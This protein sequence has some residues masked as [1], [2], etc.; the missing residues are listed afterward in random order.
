MCPTEPDIVCGTDGR[1]YTNLCLLNKQACQSKSQL[2]I[3]YKGEC[4]PGVYVGPGPVYG[5]M[6]YVVLAYRFMTSV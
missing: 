6:T 3:L 4:T 5:A 1:T 2:Q